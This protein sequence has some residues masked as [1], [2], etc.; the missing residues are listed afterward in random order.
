V[1]GGGVTCVAVVLGVAYALL[2]TPVYQSNLL[3]Q[4]EDSAPDA[5]NFLGDTA[6]LFDVK[7]PATGEIQ[8]IRSRMVMGGAVEATRL[9]ID[10]QPRYVPVIGEWLARRAKG[11]SSQ[12]FWA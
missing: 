4:V 9:Y 7:T 12:A 3:V 10:A 6:N 11:L 5:K 1:A 8:I 2:S